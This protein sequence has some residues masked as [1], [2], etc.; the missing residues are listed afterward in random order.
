MYDSFLGKDSVQLQH[1]YHMHFLHLSEKRIF[2]FVAAR[3]EVM[4]RQGRSK[5]EAKGSEVWK[6]ME[7]I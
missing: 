7:H 6:H 2:D 4:G 5:R 3:V 1:P